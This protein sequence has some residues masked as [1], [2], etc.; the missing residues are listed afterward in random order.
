MHD[1]LGGDMTPG[2]TWRRLSQLALAALIGVASSAALAQTK[3]TDSIAVQAV[4]EAAAARY[5][6]ENPQ[7]AAIAI[8]VVYGPSRFQ[9]RAGTLEPGKVRPPLPD[10]LFPLASITKTF[11][12]ALLAQA[13]I[14]KRL[15]LSDDVRKYLNGEY[16]NLEFEGR[17]ILVSDLLDHRSGLPFLLPDRPEL[18]PDFKGDARPY[19]VRVNAAMQGYGR[20]QFFS[21]LHAVKLTAMPESHYQY[22]NAGAQLAGYILEKLYGQPYEQVLRAKILNP[23]R[24]NAT[25]ISLSLADHNRLAP[26][27]DDKGQR[28]ILPV[29]AEAAGGMKSTTDDMLNYIRWQV[30][31]TDPAVKLSHQRVWM[32]KGPVFGDQGIFGVGLNWQVA[33]LSGRR[34]IFQDGM[35][36]GYSALVVIEPGSKLGIV[37][38]A[39]QLDQKS[40]AAQRGLM[41]ALL[42]ALDP[43]SVPLPE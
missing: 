26:G 39:N 19:T 11:T 29:G 12:G 32:A 6:Q 10:T 9:S 22:S 42:T 5:I 1:L 20:D 4:V 41:K 8:G 35:I 30:D 18:A 15:S 21:D 14:E 31:E 2:R 16:P 37:L 3:P 27:W 28:A 23:L 33:E 25:T 40:A 43:Q 36:E 34:V 24:M 38:T 13:V 7:A 17:A